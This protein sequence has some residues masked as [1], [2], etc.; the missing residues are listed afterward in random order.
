[1]TGGHMDDQP[2][3]SPRLRPTGG[4]VGDGRPADF[5]ST[6]D[7]PIDRSMNRSACLIAPRRRWCALASCLALVLAISGCGASAHAGAGAGAGAGGGTVIGVTERDFH[8]S[9]S[10]SNVSAG[11]VSLRIS[12]QG[13]DQHE[14]IV[15]PDLKA[16]LPI[17]ADGFTVDE[18]AIQ[19]SEPGAITPQQP[20]GTE[21]LRLHLASGRYVLFCNMEGHYMGGMRTELVVR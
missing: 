14:L 20:G 18:E 3:G 1:M 7:L 17:R 8:I 10:I 2:R 5:R 15:A 4:L 16:G 6:A 21:Y 13:P 9:T 11:D 12:N 19:H